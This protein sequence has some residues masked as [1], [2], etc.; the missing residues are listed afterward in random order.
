[1][2]G[3]AVY[4][5]KVGLEDADKLGSSIGGV[6]AV[7]ALLAPYLL[8]RREEAAVPD[9]VVVEDSGDADATGGGEANTGA[10]TV[11][12][13]T[14]TVRVTRSGNAVADGPGSVANTGVRR[15]PR[16]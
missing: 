1:M 14:G 11:D 9:E 6:A 13:D 16:T 2:A 10:E 12:G 7:A 4:L 8:P 5:F 3:L 15:R